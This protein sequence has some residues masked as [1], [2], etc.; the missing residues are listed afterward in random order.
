MKLPERIADQIYNVLYDTSDS[1][2]STLDRMDSRDRSRMF[3]KLITVIHAEL[4]AAH[5]VVLVPA[6]NVEAK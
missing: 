3:D 1:M 6:T 5:A 2:A 4:T